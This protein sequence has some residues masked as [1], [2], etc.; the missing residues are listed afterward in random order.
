MQQA[1]TC[2]SRL[3]PPSRAPIDEIADLS[4]PNGPITNGNASSV[5]SNY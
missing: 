3:Q 1:A 4:R 2:S 5:V